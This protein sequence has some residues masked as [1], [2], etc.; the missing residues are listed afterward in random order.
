MQPQPPLPHSTEHAPA[1]QFFFML[2]QLTCWCIYKYLFKIICRAFG[3]SRNTN[4]SHDT[5]IGIILYLRAHILNTHQTLQ[6]ILHRTHN[7]LHI[8]SPKIC[9]TLMYAAVVACLS[10]LVVFLYAQFR[11]LLHQVIKRK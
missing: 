5:K 11:G 4:F 10:S 3:N 7:V 9:P 8:D 6:A 1:S 2:I